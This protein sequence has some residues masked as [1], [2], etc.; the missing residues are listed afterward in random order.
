MTKKK[1]SKKRMLPPSWLP[2]EEVWTSSTSDTKAMHVLAPS[3]SS[4]GQP[5]YCLVRVNTLTDHVN[6][7]VQ[8]HTF[9]CKNNVLKELCMYIS[10]YLL[11]Y[12]A[13]Q[14]WHFSHAIAM[15]RSSFY[16]ETDNF[17]NN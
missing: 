10:S 2:E 15:S 14:E 8:I 13:F 6:L 4:T 11:Y 17:S 5:T 12:A 9:F 7:T 3:S 1:T 16:L